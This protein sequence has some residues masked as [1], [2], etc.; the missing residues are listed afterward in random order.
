VTLALKKAADRATAK[1]SVVAR[2]FVTKPGVA[3]APEAAP[4]Q[5][6]V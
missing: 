1:K 3:A 5:A 4:A 2:K 6:I